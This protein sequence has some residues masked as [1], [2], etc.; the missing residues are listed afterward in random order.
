MKTKLT[1]FLGHDPQLN[2]CHDPQ[3]NA[4]HSNLLFPTSDHFINPSNITCVL[5]SLIF[6]LFLLPT[7]T[8]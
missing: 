6:R 4:S 8:L 2:S 1:I 5:N 7:V 3:E